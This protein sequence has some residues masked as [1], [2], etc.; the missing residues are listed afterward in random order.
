MVV[1]R[2]TPAT[3]TPST[4]TLHF[5]R[6]GI[7]CRRLKTKLGGVSGRVTFRCYDPLSLSPSLEIGREWCVGVSERDTQFHS[8]SFTTHPTL[9]MGFSHSS[10]L[11]AGGQFPPSQLGFAGRTKMEWNGWDSGMDGIRMDGTRKGMGL[12]GHWYPWSCSKS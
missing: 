5:N 9:Y 12:G 11:V 10:S 4:P 7:L 6:L 8:V 2:E 3:P 1:D